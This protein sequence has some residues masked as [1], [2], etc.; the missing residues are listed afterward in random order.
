[1]RIG[2][3]HPGAM[4]ATIGGLLVDGG[5]EVRWLPAGRSPETA[6][7][8]A[9]A[10]LTAAD[11]LGDAQAIL[12]VCPPHAALEVARGLQG[13]RGLVIDANAVSPMTAS[14]IGE[15][16]GESWVD[17]AIVGPPPLR[18]G[19]TRLYLSGARAAEAAE[20]F[21][22]SALEPL[23]LPGSPVAASALKMSYAAWT[24]G[25]A[26]LLLAAHESARVNG[27]EDA[28][29]AEWQRSLPGLEERARQA[30]DS[31]AS[32]GWRWV[33]EMREIAA[34]FAEAGLPPGFHEAAAEM[35][36]RAP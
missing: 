8:A 4:G 5:H 28:L 29:V 17:A 20:L 12:S 35:F 16:L 11:D 3:L 21:R 2:L 36:Q 6:R 15:L 22:G 33:G 7:R 25:S 18:A 10:G 34:A 24:K 27:V 14:R 30:A 31:A 1:M 26:A 19:T 23:V 32:K 13:A 9:D